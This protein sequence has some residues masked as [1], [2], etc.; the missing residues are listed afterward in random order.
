MFDQVWL[1]LT[2]R[3]IKLIE[4][5]LSGLDRRNRQSPDEI[6]KLSGKLRAAKGHPDI[7][8]GVHGGMVQWIR[9]NPFP[10]RICDYDGDGRDL[11]DI[12]EQGERCSM[13]REPADFTAGES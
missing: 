11:T 5:A 2:V 12:D 3:E 1:P 4:E 13:W 7:T 9:G 8:V 6:Q 10:I